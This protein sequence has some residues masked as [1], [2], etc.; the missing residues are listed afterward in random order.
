MGRGQAQEGGREGVSDS[1][2]RQ[3]RWTTG[4]RKTATAREREKRERKASGH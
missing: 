3:R 1:A 2:Q 4:G